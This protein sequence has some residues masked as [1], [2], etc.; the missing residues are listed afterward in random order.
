MRAN[1]KT[2]K[3]TQRFRCKDPACGASASRANTRD[4]VA[5]RHE[6]G[7]FFNWLFTGQMPDHISAKTFHRRTAWCWNI[8]PPQPEPT[9]EIHRYLM[10][11]GTYFNGYCV[12]VAYN[13]AHVVGWQYC[14]REKNASWTL[15][16]QDL[17]AP[18]IAVVDGNGPLERVMRSLWPDTSVQ[19][20]YFHIR[21]RI[22]THLTRNPRTQPGRELLALVK[23]LN[24]ITTPD[25]AA[26]FQAEFAS[27]ASRWDRVLKERTYANQGRS[28]RPWHV[29]PGQKWW[30]THL[31]LRRAYKLINGLITGQKLF[32]WMTHGQPYETLPKTTNPLECGVNTA[33][34]ELLRKHRGLRP[35][36][37]IK[38]VG[39]LL[40]FKTENPADPWS[41]V[42]AQHWDTTTKP[43][44]KQPP[45]ERIGP[46][47]YDTAFSTQ[48]GNGIQQGWGGRTR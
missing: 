7:W 8:T 37:A 13:G 2:P 45:P 30:Y 33:A 20:C 27:W 6:L 12:L 48:D 38:A 14:D 47:L 39:W 11:D 25:Q 34:K 28:E 1:G 26:A 19:R 31:R 10:L 36:H 41:F 32:T 40:Y 23:T 46:A 24:T 44:T 3:G 43:K 17:P 15:L 9:G 21:Q 35:D 29:R 18:D 4:D 22:H 16:I 42:T 5:R